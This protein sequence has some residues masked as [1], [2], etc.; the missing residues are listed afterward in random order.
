MVL[1]SVLPLLNVMS[2]SKFATTSK[3][4]QKISDKYFSP[5]KMVHTRAFTHAAKTAKK[6]INNNRLVRKI[7]SN[8]NNQIRNDINNTYRK[9]VNMNY[10]LNYYKNKNSRVYKSLKTKNVNFPQR[11][12]TQLVLVNFQTQPY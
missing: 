9:L 4:H 8:H 5:T 6:P 11:V 1:S 12:G 3:K 7:I 10:L 2:V